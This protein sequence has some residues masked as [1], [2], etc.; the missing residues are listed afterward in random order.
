MAIE[1]LY[2][3]VHNI[4]KEQMGIVNEMY[5]PFI[6]SLFVFV[7]ISNL[8]GNVVYNFCIST[9][10]IYT[11]GLSL[12]IFI[13]VTV[14]GLFLHKFIFFSFFV[15]SGAPLI[16]VPILSLVELVSY[17]AR[18]VSLG[19]RLFSNITAGHSLLTI[20]SGFLLPIFKKGILILTVA[21]LPLSLF[22]ALVGLE[23]AVSFIQA[24]VFTLLTSSYIKD[25]I[26]LH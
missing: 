5:F 19:V 12:T 24:Y 3:S 25:S 11:L 6:Y 15:P 4:V 8:I 9:S 17:L 26:E 13:G 22:I 20:L 7:L 1:A 23:I 2:S 14:L 10:A 21:I 18:A 16:I